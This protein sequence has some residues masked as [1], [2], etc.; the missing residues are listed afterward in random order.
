MIDCRGFFMIS[1]VLPD[2]QFPRGF[3]QFPERQP[4][5]GELLLKNGKREGPFAM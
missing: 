5:G 4:G 3:I 1:S 2:K